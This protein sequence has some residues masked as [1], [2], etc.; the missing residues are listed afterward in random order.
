[1]S[2]SH[3]VKH[4]GRFGLI[5]LVLV[6]LESIVMI[7][8][9][10]SL[11]FPSNPLSMDSDTIWL[12]IV[13]MLNIA[14]FI[15]ISFSAILNENL[16]ELYAFLLFRTFV[17]IRV[18]FDVIDRDDTCRESLLLAYCYSMFAFIMGFYGVYIVLICC[19]KRELGWRFY[20]EVGVKLELKKCYSFYQAFKTC[21]K[22][23]TYS[24]GMLIFSC[25]Y[26]SSGDD[27][28][29]GIVLSVVMLLVAISWLVL[30][31]RAIHK[32]N[33]CMMQAFLASAPLT[34]VYAIYFIVMF[35][36]GPESYRGTVFTSV[37][38]VSVLAMVMR[39]AL[40]VSAVM[41]YQ[42]FGNGLLMEVFAR[43]RD[44]ENLQR[45]RTV[46]EIE[47]SGVDHIDMDPASS[48]SKFYS[49]IES[50]LGSDPISSEHTTFPEFGLDPTVSSDDLKTSGPELG[51]ALI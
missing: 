5:F 27:F 16:F 38:V 37:L 9:G 14:F 22:L 26:F 25:L 17:S 49:D 30:G 41:L 33:R 2:C 40:I 12:F 39:A 8:D 1:M 36:E 10:V 35:A 34:P 23:D 20:K 18:I 3:F 24:C 31:H 44:G 46:M 19:L 32:E 48:N 11:R 47:D 4:I 21:V 28:V 13:N 43:K 6:V 51:D 7:V 29:V 42:Q 50:D 45:R 15:H